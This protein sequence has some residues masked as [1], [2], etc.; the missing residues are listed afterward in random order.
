VQG[1]DNLVPMLFDNPDLLEDLKSAIKEKTE[2][3]EE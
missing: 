2:S 1:I 3:K